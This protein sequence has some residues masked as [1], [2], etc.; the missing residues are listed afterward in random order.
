MPERHH[1]QP[2]ELCLPLVQYRFI[3]NQL[4]TFLKNYHL[5]SVWFFRWHDV[6]CKSSAQFF[7]LNANIGVVPDSATSSSA[8][9]LTSGQS[10]IKTSGS[11]SFGSGIQ[12]SASAAAASSSFGGVGLTAS[13]SSGSS[14]FA[15]G[16]KKQANAGYNY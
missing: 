11:G 3:L 2:G 5:T 4:I 15:G 10:A 1:L 13:A 12:I 14:T 6:E 7:N 8:G 9:R 16:V